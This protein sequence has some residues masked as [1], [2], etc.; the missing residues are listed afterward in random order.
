MV[1]LL[2]PRHI[3]PLCTTCKIMS[4]PA[5]ARGKAR[6]S[7]VQMPLDEIQVD[8]IPNP[9]HMGLSTDTRFNYFLILCDRFSR[10]FRICGIR[11]KTTDACID[12]IELIIS[13]MPGCRGSSSDTTTNK[14]NPYHL[15]G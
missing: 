3:D 4:N 15:I 7:R 1:S 11:D 5:H 8:P 13:T 9:E 14:I 2:D 6:E 12:G 10:T